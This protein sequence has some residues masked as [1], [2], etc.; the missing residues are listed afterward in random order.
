MRLPLNHACVAAV[1]A[2]ESCCGVVPVWSRRASSTYFRRGPDIAV[3]V[4]DHAADAV[5]TVPLSVLT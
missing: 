2:V 3:A 1:A 5:D 4:T